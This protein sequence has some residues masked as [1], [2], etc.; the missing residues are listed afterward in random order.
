MKTLLLQFLLLF[1]LSIKGDAFNP[2]LRLPGRMN[3]ND[4]AA[5][6]QP[7]LSEQQG[8][9]SGKG[10]GRC[11]LDKITKALKCGMKK[12]DHLVESTPA[13]QPKIRDHKLSQEK[14][15]EKSSSK[16][17]PLARF[18][19]AVGTI[20][21][22]QGEDHKLRQEVFRNA[23]NQAVKRDNGMQALKD[24]I[25]RFEEDERRLY[26]DEKEKERRRIA[27]EIYHPH[28]ERNAKN[29][30]KIQAWNL[31]EKKEREKKMALREKEKE[32]RLKK[33]EEFLAKKREEAKE[34]AASRPQVESEG[35]RRWRLSQYLEAHNDFKGYR[36]RYQRLHDAYKQFGVPMISK[37]GGDLTMW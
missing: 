31:A 2:K 19:K 7:S 9:S 26:G 3:P 6:K 20:Q 10:F 23:A 16:T 11:F 12:E 25:R 37:V 22:Q 17:A 4:G 13:N 1:F 28:I 27:V 5:V 29:V 36:D 15:K 14:Q 32:E 34:K 21:R 18:Q 30:D 24:R 33:K 8:S 35:S